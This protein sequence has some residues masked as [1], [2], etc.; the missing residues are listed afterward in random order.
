MLGIECRDGERW[1]QDAS[2]RRLVRLRRFAEV[3]GS[4]LGDVFIIASGP[5][6]RRFPLYDYRRYPCLAMNGSILACAEH[7]IAPLFYLCDD[8]SFVRDRGALAL[9]GLALASHVAMSLEVLSR[10][11]EMD[12]CCLD[13]KSVFLLERVNR[14]VGQPRLSDR[15]YA[16]SIR[17][18][19]ELVT[20]FSWIRRAPNRIG[21]SLS[22]D[23]GYFVARTIPYVALQL[24]HQ[25]GSRRVFL[26]GV[27]L[28]PASGRFYEVGDN[29]VLSSLDEDYGKY[30]LPSFQLMA[31]RVVEPGRFEVFNLSGDSRMPEQVI[32]K[33]SLRALEAL[34]SA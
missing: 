8:Q 22:L 24:S 9:Q 14:F 29:A 18:D 12:S 30:I 3:A 32:P 28:T 25:L 17:K 2:G 15:A 6:T 16:W 33:L 10:L 5:S 27:D 26:L 23:K 1:L 20:S 4:M 7:G 21:F 13:G 31:Q 11:H 19:K 34:L